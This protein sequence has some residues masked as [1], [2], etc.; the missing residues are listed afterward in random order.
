LHLKDW[1]KK[2]ALLDKEL[3]FWEK[4][5]HSLPPDRYWRK[6]VKTLHAIQEEKITLH[7]HLLAISSVPYDSKWLTEGKK[8]VVFWAKILSEKITKYQNLHHDNWL[9]LAW[10]RFIHVRASGLWPTYRGHLPLS[11]PPVQQ[12]KFYQKKLD[13]FSDS[14]GLELTQMRREKQNLQKH[15]D[16]L[17][18]LKENR[19]AEASIPSR[20]TLT[21]IAAL[22]KLYL[23]LKT[24]QQK[25]LLD[26]LSTL[27]LQAHSKSDFEYNDSV[28]LLSST[29]LKNFDMM[30]LDDELTMYEKG[31]LF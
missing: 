4:E 12:I 13:S 5:V 9:K 23:K 14:I 11:L 24:K 7:Q 28:H 26:A 20:P 30:A 18:V 1:D 6:I 2:F 31:Q 25:P 3:Q 29:S 22:N 19:D 21:H 10:S 17:L 15:Y 27:P 16:F 8:T